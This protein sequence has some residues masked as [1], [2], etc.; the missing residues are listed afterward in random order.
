MTIPLTDVPPVD[1][2]PPL[3]ISDAAETLV[4]VRYTVAPENRADFVTQ[5]QVVR[6]TRRRTGAR[7]WELYDDREDSHV[8]V[9]AFAVGSWREHLSQHEGRMTGFDQVGL[10]RARA[11]AEGEPE[12]RHLTQI[13]PAAVVLSAS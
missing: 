10:D 1:D 12:V 8:I 6:Q 7:R 13:D 5:M 2:V 9:E 3:S 11:L 4:L